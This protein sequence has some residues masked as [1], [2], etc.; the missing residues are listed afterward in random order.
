VKKNNSKLF[1]VLIADE[2]EMNYHY[3]CEQ[4]G[5][6]VYSRDEI[7]DCPQCKRTFKSDSNQQ[8]LRIFHLCTQLDDKVSLI[9]QRL[10]AIEQNL[11]MYLT[12]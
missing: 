6:T 1:S 2:T 11:D 7:D 12:K 5:A 10:T 8:A 3:E 9:E 4:C